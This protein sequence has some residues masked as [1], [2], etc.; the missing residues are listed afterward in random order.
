MSGN[1]RKRRGEPEDLF[2]LFDEDFED[3]RD[4]MDR[5]LEQFMRGQLPPG[6]RPL[7]YGLSISTGTDG[8]PMLQEFGN[9]P[10]QGR[11][12]EEKEPRREPLTDIIE[13]EDKVTVIMELPGANKEDIQIDVDER[14]LDVNV[15]MPEKRFRKHLD[16]P[17]DVLP[18][19]SK[20][21]Y[22]NGVLD[23]VLK[24]AKVRK[25]GKK[26]KVE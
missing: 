20:A 1:E 5:I 23:L 10:M 6:Q 19:S 12:A 14:S 2:D 22:K 16:L 9:A 11:M 17:C 13:S 4:R 25:K 8:A 15:D 18:D 21:N 3:L 7:V 26:I 24:R